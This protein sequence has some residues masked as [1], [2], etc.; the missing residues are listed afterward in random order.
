MILIIIHMNTDTG[1]MLCEGF[2]EKN[3]LSLLSDHMRQIFD[4][5][6]WARIMVR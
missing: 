5:L 3:I 2:S 4:D 1:I 6:Y